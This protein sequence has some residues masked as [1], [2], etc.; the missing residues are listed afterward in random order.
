MK[1][2]LESLEIGEGKV[3]LSSEEI[4]SILTEHGKSI[5][6]ET[7]KIKSDLE[8]EID[9]Y[10]GQLKTANDEIKSYKD[11]DIDSIKQSADDWETKYNELVENQKAEKEKNIRQERTNVFFNDVKFSSEMA[12]AGVIAK[13]NE[14]DFKYDEESK[15]FQGAKEWLED[16]KKNDANSFLS[17]IA[18]PSFSTT[19][20]A[21]MQDSSMDSIL[22]A[23]GL[24]EEAKK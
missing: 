22:N 8:K 21:P 1:S 19:P 10:K 17:D 5:T 6:T 14:K 3:K 16:L 24:S 23:M 13:F 12:K 4:K 7:E 9:T 15:S 20:T 18:N 11:M 2:F